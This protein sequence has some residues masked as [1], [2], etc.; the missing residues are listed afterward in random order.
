MAISVTERI[1]VERACTLNADGHTD[2]R[3]QCDTK[4]VPV[5]DFLSQFGNGVVQW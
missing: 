4:L 2:S 3:P 1:P 5:I